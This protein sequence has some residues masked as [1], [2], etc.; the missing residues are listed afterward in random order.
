[1]ET[2]LGN[3]ARRLAQIGIG[4]RRT[5]GTQ[6]LENT[7]GM[8]QAPFDVVEQIEQLWVHGDGVAGVEIPKEVIEPMES[9]SLVT[10]S[11]TIG[12]FDFLVSMKVAE[13][14]NAWLVVLFCR[15]RGRYCSG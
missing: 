13:G 5:V 1:V 2:A 14:E 10:V 11:D 9:V 6:Y 3:A 8:T 4:S 15:K 12:Y 7:I